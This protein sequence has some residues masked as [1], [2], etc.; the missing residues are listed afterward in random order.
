M[1]KLTCLEFINEITLGNSWRDENDNTNIIV[2]VDK[3]L[4]TPEVTFSESDFVDG[5]LTVT[6]ED[7]EKIVITDY[8]ENHNLE[9]ETVC[10]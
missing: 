1:K 7:G 9:I 3:F 10:E 6:F 2:T 4:D 8:K 5:A